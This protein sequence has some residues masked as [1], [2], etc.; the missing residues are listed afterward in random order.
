MFRNKAHDEAIIEI[1]TSEG[2][3]SSN[4]PIKIKASFNEARNKAEIWGGPRSMRRWGRRRAREDQSAEQPVDSSSEI[5]SPTQSDREH[6]QRRY[7][8]LPP[9]PASLE[10]DGIAISGTRRYERQWGAQV[11]EPWGLEL[12]QYDETEEAKSVKGKSPA[13]TH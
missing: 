4:R 9:P 2:L 8:T 11:N 1:G 5:T 13:Y 6:Q 12:Y 7:K 3:I 10:I